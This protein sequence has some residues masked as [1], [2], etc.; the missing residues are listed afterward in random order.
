MEPITIS[1]ENQ[2]PPTQARSPTQDV[3]PEKGPDS[4]RLTE[5]LDDVHKGL[6]AIHNVDLRFSVHE[7][8]GKIMVTVTDGST[9]EVIRQLPPSEILD[10]AAR[11]D[12]MIGLIFDQK[13]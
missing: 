9:G 1:V 11:V 7:A 3:K 2:T 13:G 4:S 12:K 6:D 5:L 10:I 8:S